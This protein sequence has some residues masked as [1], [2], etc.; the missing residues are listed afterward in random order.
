[1]AARTIKGGAIRGLADECV[2]SAHH[3][4]VGLL[5]AADNEAHGAPRLPQPSA[6]PRGNGSTAC[7]AKLPLKQF[8]TRERRPEGHGTCL[9]EAQCWSC[10]DGVACVAILRPR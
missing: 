3:A 10:Q 6:A 4:S 1:M 5:E 9:Q 8:C 2:A 7:V